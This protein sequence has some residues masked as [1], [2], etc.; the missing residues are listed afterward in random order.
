LDGFERLPFH[1]LRQL[2]EEGRDA[3]L[4]LRVEVGGGHGE[5][6]KPASALRIQMR[7]RFFIEPSRAQKHA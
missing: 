4:D 3:G 5:V 1:E 7:D 2:A 6:I